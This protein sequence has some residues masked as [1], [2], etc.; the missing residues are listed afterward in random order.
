MH[1]L[2]RKF[3]KN[4]MALEMLKELLKGAPVQERDTN[5]LLMFYSKLQSKHRLAVTFGRAHEFDA[6]IV[7]QEV[8]K[9]VP[10]LAKKWVSK[11]VK[12]STRGGKSL[13]FVDF[14][15]YLDEQHSEAD[16][17]KA[18]YPNQASGPR[19][20]R[21]SMVGAKRTGTSGVSGPEHPST[22]EAAI[23]AATAAPS[24]CLACSGDH[25]IDKCEEFAKLNPDNMK[26]T[27]SRSR[28]CFRCGDSSHMARRCPA[29]L[30]CATCNGKHATFLHPIQTVRVTLPVDERP[31][32]PPQ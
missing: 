27:L 22:P 7:I 28:G 12:V 5:G 26:L 18:F 23:N 4:E 8:L 10:H 1:A 19:N 30:T 11:V 3:L 13:T 15:T 16:K 17:M 2:G 6:D 9:K 32:P 25:T 31:P 21:V 20:P 14:L 24:G 29:R